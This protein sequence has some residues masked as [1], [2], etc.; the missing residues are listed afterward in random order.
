M[1]AYILMTALVAIGILSFL[2]IPI[3]RVERYC[4]NRKVA[5]VDA[6]DYDAL[7]EL[8]REAQSEIEHWKEKADQNCS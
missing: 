2:L 6:R 8:Y 7:L 3:K 1:N 4:S 5:F